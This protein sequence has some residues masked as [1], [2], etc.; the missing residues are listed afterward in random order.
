M[1]NLRVATATVQG[2]CNAVVDDIDLGA[3][4]GT[5]K[6]YDGAQPANA[7]T[8]VSTQTL[9]GT[10]TFSDPAF[11]AADASGIATA[12]AITQDASADATGTATWARIADSN[13]LT[14]F[15]CDVGTSAATIVL[16][17]VSIVAGGTIDITAFTITQPSGV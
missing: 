10:L 5:I 14:K 6:I 12:G 16:D 17:S 1:T 15:D 4:A 8:A 2:Q 9:L 3:G 11:G 7:N 13:G